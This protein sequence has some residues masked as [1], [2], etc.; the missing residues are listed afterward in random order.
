MQWMTDAQA[1]FFTKIEM[2]R[3]NNSGPPYIQ[4]VSP[5]LSPL[6]A[7]GLFCSC[8]RRAQSSPFALPRPIHRPCAG[9]LKAAPRPIAPTPPLLSRLRVPHPEPRTLNPFLL[10]YR[11]IGIP[12]SRTQRAKKYCPR[13]PAVRRTWC[14]GF[15]LSLGRGFHAKIRRL[16]F[17]DGALKPTLAGLMSVRDRPRSGSAEKTT[18]GFCTGKI[19][20]KASLFPPPHRPAIPA[21]PPPT[22]PAAP[23]TPP[24]AFSSLPT[25]PPTP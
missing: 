25:P 23:L 9:V 18:V 2:L 5:R 1:S 17:E 8:A 10:S 24:P 3:M 7:Q 13:V 16:F 19:Q 11:R 6:C 12:P 21:P 15:L 22:T 4:P 14:R 20:T